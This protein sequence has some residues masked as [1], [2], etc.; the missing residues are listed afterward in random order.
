[1]RTFNRTT[2]SQIRTSAGRWGR[3][4]AYVLLGVGG[5]WRADT[6]CALTATIPSGLPL[7]C[8]IH[9][10]DQIDPEL[11][12]H[13]GDSVGHAPLLVHAKQLAEELACQLIAYR[14][15]NGTAMS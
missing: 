12:S 14:P 13:F 8:A 11:V 5:E 7:P 3:N 4:D 15:L 10:C 9:E 6:R 2:K 1:M